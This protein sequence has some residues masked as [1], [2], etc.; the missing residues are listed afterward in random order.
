MNLLLNSTCY[1]KSENPW[2]AESE[3][4]IETPENTF[5]NVLIDI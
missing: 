4:E 5:E 1:S 2:A 3:I